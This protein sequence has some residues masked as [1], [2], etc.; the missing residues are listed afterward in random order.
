MSI[1][2]LFQHLAFAAA[3]TILSAAITWLMLHRVRI[4]DEPNA[5]SSHQQATPRGGGVAIV[6]TFL[7]GV[8]LI[9]LLGEEVQIHQHYFWVFLLSSVLIAAI[10][11]YDDITQKSFQIKLATQVVAIALAISAGLV[12]DGTTVAVLDGLPWLA[13]TITVVWLLGM[14]NAYNFMDG[15]DGMAAITAIV[16]SLFFAVITLSHGSNFAYLVSF[17]VAAGAA[18]FLCFNWPPASIFMGDVGS[19]FLGFVLAALALMAASYDNSHTSFFVMPLLLFHYIFDTAFTMGR[20]ILAGENPAQAHRGHLY[21]LLVRMGSSH[22]Q[23]TLLYA[24]LVVIQGGAALMIDSL[25]GL[26]RLWLFVPF[27]LLYSVAA[28]WIVGRARV[29]GLIT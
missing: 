19:A 17:V 2:I 6:T 15:I 8:G 9:E 7:V 26:D 11:L 27:L 20:R 24:G 12:L 25:L 28:W 23:V 1:W 4:M 5:R 18:G 13:I 22:R 3:L 14:T 29:L 10:S 21:Q 16:V